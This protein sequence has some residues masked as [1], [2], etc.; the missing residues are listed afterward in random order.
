[1]LRFL[2]EMSYDQI[3]QVIDCQ[4]G[5][6]KSRIFYAKAALKR[7]LERTNEHV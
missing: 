5:T 3:A 4:P 6:V 2:E 7:I 1:M